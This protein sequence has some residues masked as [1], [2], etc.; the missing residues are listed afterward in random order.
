[1]WISL[2]FLL[3][4]DSI[5]V[6]TRRTAGALSTFSA[7]FPVS[8]AFFFS[9][10]IVSIPDSIFWIWSAG[11]STGRIVIPEIVAASSKISGSTGKA[12]ATK[13][14]PFSK[15]TGTISLFTIK[16]SGSISMAAGSA[17]R[18]SKWMIS[19]SSRSL[20]QFMITSSVV[21]PKRSNISVRLLSS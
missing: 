17:V 4:A 5:S 12:Q 19:M 3:Y 6:L 21:Y 16:D 8:A 11:V 10:V 15:H 2:A 9:S 13:R 7:V 1:M 18:S 14:S 20:K